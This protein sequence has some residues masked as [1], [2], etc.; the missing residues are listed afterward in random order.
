[1]LR[2]GINQIRSKGQF[3]RNERIILVDDHVFLLD[4]MTDVLSKDFTIIGRFSDANSF[5]E[6]AA[7]L[8][9]NVV[10]LDVGMP[11]MSG[12][13]A[14]S[15]VKK[16]LPRVKIVFLTMNLD[17][18]SVAEAFRN[19]ADG[20][21]LKTSAATELV[22]AIRTVLRGGSFISPDLTDGIVGSPVH[23]YKKMKSPHGL[24]R[25][26]TEVLRLFANGRTISEIAATLGIAPRT[27]A[28]HRAC[29]LEE[30]Q[31]QS[32]SELIAYGVKHFIVPNEGS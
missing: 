19:G 27:V 5:L 9:P 25:R 18:N 3:V 8:I 32:T 10:V 2:L 17:R 11:G 16:L 26:Q 20:Y 1:M 21:V 15:R 23:T 22:H 6:S 12:I 28:F 30:L 7:E 29:L 14:C 4:L 13:S 24:T 31:L